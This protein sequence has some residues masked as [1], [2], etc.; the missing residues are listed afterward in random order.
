MRP[1]DQIYCL[2]AGRE[3]GLRLHAQFIS[4]IHTQQAQLS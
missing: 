4:V 2:S 3:K 1:L